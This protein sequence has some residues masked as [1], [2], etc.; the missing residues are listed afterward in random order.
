MRIFSKKELAKCNGKGGA[1]VYI[2]YK[3]KV[4][5]VSN[6]FLWQG[7]THQVLHSVGKDLTNSIAEAPHG[8]ELLERF[9]VVGKM[10]ES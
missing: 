4:Y 1:K 3:G 2:A 9:P 7:G 6:S 8:P 5:D 10:E